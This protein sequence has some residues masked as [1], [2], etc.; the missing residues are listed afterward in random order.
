[1]SCHLHAL[2]VY[3]RVCDFGDRNR[4]SYTQGAQ[5]RTLELVDTLAEQEESLLTVK[6]TIQQ[7]E[8]ELEREWRVAS[9]MW[10][11]VT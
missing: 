1:M 11:S 4:R 3:R 6:T 9:S 8:Q 7:Q 2:Q 5:Q 10:S